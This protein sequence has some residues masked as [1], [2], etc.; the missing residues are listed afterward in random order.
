MQVMPLAVM[1]FEDSVL[2]ASCAFLLELCGL[3]PSMLQVDIAALR[4]IS[5]FFKSIEH[6]DNSAQ[7]SFKG[8]AFLEGDITGSMA[9][10]LAEHYLKN[11]NGGAVKERDKQSSTKCKQA[12]RALVL[13]L[14]NLE[15]ASLPSLVSG[16]TS[17]SWLMTGNGNGADLRAQQKAASQHWI[18]VTE[19]C[20][21]HQIPI[22]TKYLAVLAKDNDWVL[23]IYVKVFLNCCLTYVLENIKWHYCFQVGFLSEAQV[24]GHPLDVV[25]QV[26]G[27]SS[28][29]LL[30][31]YLFCTFF[32]FTSATSRDDITGLTIN[33]FCLNYHSFIDFF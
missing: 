31:L 14:Q 22:S 21:M 13:V 4:R 12:S 23:T 30:F 3:S 17:G 24:E 7:P 20:K 25:I 18:L 11:Y 1:H 16:E 33:T 2:V 26:V 15:K 8:S 6:A 5:S 32:C 10:A 28:L 27:F 9:R 29:S 19:F